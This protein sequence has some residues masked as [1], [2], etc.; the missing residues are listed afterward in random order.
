MELFTNGGRKYYFNLE[1]MMEEILYLQKLFP[2]KD[3]ILL[4]LKVFNIYLED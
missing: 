3:S 1:L 4:I 2:L